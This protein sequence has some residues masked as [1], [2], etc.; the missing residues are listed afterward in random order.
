M[1]TNESIATR[2]GLKLQVEK[3]IEP[4]GI[5]ICLRAKSP[6]PCVFHWGVR[7][8]TDT[9]WALPPATA[10]PPG[11]VAT[12]SKALRTPLASG[13]GD[14]EITIR[15]DPAANFAFIN[16]VL[17]FP[18]ESRWDNNNGKNYEIALP[19]AGDSGGGPEEAVQHW[20]GSSEA[21]AKR[22]FETGPRRQLA[23]AAKKSDTAYHVALITNLPGPLLLHWG[24]AR[25]SPYEWLL[26]PESMRPA[27]T[28]L[29]GTLAA[30][31]PFVSGEVLGELHFEFPES[32]APLGMQFV[33][34]QGDN[35]LKDRGGNFYLPVSAT[36][37]KAAS[38]DSAQLNAL[39]GEVIRAEAHGSWTLMHRFNL[40][41]D[42]LEHARGGNAEVLALLYVWL[43]YSA[44]RQLTWQRN[45][46]TKPRELSHAQERLTHKLAD[47]WRSETDG[48]PLV[49]LMLATIG[50]GG[51]GQRIRDEI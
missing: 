43:R 20:L 15:L 8:A 40:L 41:H 36:A 14:G 24:I 2:G 34:K 27:G 29:A 6:K 11:T 12:D 42:L 7:G 51:D 9:E 38:L 26:P 48:R 16:F 22:V 17:H 1:T 45:Y 23:A 10:W 46:N 4:Q 39:A 37:H 30:Q 13:K 25:R 32:D 44:I 33:L 18:D 21:I 3:R 49:R 35:W 5:A 50:R 19:V 31:T 28:I 47:F